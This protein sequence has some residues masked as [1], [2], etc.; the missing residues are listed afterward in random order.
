MKK[1][2]LICAFSAIAANL[3]GAAVPSVPWNYD[4]PIYTGRNYRVVNPRVSGALGVLLKTFKYSYLFLANDNDFENAVRVAAEI[5]DFR[6]LD[7]Y[8]EKYPGLH[9]NGV[10]LPQWIALAKQGRIPAFSASAA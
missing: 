6:N 1:L 5:G 9:F 4:G 8:G 3:N 2:L 7:A 10:T